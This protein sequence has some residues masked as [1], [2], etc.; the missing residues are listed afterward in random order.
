MRPLL[1]RTLVYA[2]VSL[3]ATCQ[4]A[5]TAPTRAQSGEPAGPCD[6]SGVVGHLEGGK[7]E[8]ILHRGSPEQLYT[9]KDRSGRVVVTCASAKRLHEQHPEVYESIGSLI[10]TLEAPDYGYPA[11]TPS[12][13]QSQEVTRERLRA[14]GYI[15][16]K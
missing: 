3:I 10:R 2:A 16:G 9:V 12:L 1:A 5:H 15:E 13:T 6:T 14:L 11:S 8:L 7:Y 4:N